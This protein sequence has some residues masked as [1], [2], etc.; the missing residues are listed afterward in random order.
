MPS[1]PGSHQQLGNWRRVCCS[2]SSETSS[3]KESEHAS[4]D[5]V[6]RGERPWT[7]SDECSRSRRS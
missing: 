6:A 4:F 2:A 1:S 7:T 3:V 5:L